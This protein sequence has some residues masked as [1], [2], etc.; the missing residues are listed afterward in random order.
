MA[1]PRWDGV[2]HSLSLSSAPSPDVVSEL[3]GMYYCR[4]PWGFM[5]GLLWGS[6][7]EIDMKVFY[8]WW[9][10]LFSTE[11][12]EF[13][14][15]IGKQGKTLRKFVQFSQRKMCPLWS[16]N[17]SSSVHLINVYWG[18]LWAWHGTSC[19]GFISE[20]NRHKPLPWD[21]WGL[22]R[23]TDEKQHV[24]KKKKLQSKWS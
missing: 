2:G 12:R 24:S 23:E 18:H 17:L 1:F 21:R 13:F 5:P 8:K 22:M 9:K 16:K 11:S 3:L 19:L 4:T 6:N 10:L 14:I 7:E 15:C 20:E